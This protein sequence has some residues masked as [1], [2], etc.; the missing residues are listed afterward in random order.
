MLLSHKVVVFIS[1]DVAGSLFYP[2]RTNVSLRA[3]P[4]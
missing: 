4:V 2:V 3:T 1:D